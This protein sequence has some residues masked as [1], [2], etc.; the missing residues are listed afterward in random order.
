V[1]KAEAVSKLAMKLLSRDPKKRPRDEEDLLALA[2]V[3]DDAEWTRATES[4]GLIEARGFE[5]KRDL[6]TAMAELRALDLTED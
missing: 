3:A 4:V 5:R 6:R 1:A 2:R